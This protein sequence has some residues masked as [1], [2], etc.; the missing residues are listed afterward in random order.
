MEQVR[1]PTGGQQDGVPT[2]M[3]N[4]TQGLAHD[5]LCPSH[6]F[7]REEAGCPSRVEGEPTDPTLGKI[8]LKPTQVAEGR[9]SERVDPEAVFGQVPGS[10]SDINLPRLTPASITQALSHALFKL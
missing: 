9:D 7:G 1:T 2:A 5:L 3:T 10:I 8:K 6:T 4:G